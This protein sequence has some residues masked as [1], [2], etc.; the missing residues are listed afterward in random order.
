ME[1]NID[2]KWIVKYRRYKP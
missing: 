2:K 1:P